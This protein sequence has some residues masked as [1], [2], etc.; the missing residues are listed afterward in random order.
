MEEIVL[1]YYSSLGEFVKVGG[2]KDWCN[3]LCFYDRVI[4][5]GFVRKYGPVDIR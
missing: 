1:D 3:K 5:M 4:G 2:C